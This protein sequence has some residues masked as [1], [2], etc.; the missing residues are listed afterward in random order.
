MQN[1]QVSAQEM[2]EIRNI[3]LQDEEVAK[4]AKDPGIA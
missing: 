1:G 4:I 2:E 3:A